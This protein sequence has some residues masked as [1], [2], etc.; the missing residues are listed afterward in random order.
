MVLHAA[1]HREGYPEIA[2]RYSITWFNC[3]LILKA[4]SSGGAFL[5]LFN[6][7]LFLT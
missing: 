4:P 2:V 3:F 6:K 7:R 5:S 1:D